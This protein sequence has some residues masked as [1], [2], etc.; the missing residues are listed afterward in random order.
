VIEYSGSD[1]DLPPLEEDSQAAPPQRRVGAARSQPAEQNQ[2]FFVQPLPAW[3]RCFDIV[4][5]VLG[6]LLFG[7]LIV[8]AAAAIRLTSTGPAF[9]AQDRA[10][11]GGRPFKMLKLRTMQQGADA[12][13]HQLRD[14]SDQDG[15]AFKM[16]DDPRVTPVGRWLRK[17]SID[18][19]PQF[20]N[21]LRGEMSLV[22]PRP[23]PVEESQA[24]EIWQ[25]RR[26][27][28]TPGLTCIWQV[29]GR[30][31]VSFEEWIR[32]DIQYI[33]TR[34]LKKDVWIL[35]KTLP[36]CLGTKGAS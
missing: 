30:N 4:G 13:K 35:L 7:P 28:V 36:A 9:F 5:G 15:P 26:L 11:V 6:L 19:L 8:I 1:R 22:G 33:T 17:L 34:S 16:M 31:T 3:K 27:D 10:G 2:V 24:C 29:T 32:M 20:W 18:E 12:M 25:T 23:L 21:V 14:H